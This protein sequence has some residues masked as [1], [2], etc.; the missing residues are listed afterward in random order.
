MDIK[1]HET[2]SRT[3]PVKR[4]EAAPFMEQGVQVK[5][6]KVLVIFKPTLSL[7]V[8][9]CQTIQATHNVVQQNFLY[10]DSSGVL[11][12]FFSYMIR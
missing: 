12:M 6:N 7:I 5:P 10:P 8:L 11:L 1:S 2:T 9:L 4:D 3:L